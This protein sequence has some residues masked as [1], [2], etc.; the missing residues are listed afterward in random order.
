MYNGERFPD[1]PPG[2]KEQGYYHDFF[3]NKPPHKGFLRILCQLQA[4]GVENLRL[5]L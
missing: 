3:P 1:K 5:T 4:F 2:W